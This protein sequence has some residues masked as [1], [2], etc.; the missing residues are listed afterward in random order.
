[1][2]ICLEDKMTIRDKCLPGL[3]NPPT[4]IDLLQGGRLC[5]RIPVLT[6]FVMEQ[7]NVPLSSHPRWLEILHDGLGH[8]IYAF[9]FLQG[10]QTTGFLPLAYLQ[11]RLLG[12]FLVSLPY[13][14][15]AGVCGQTAQIRT[16][17]VSAA[18]GLA[19]ELRVRFLELRHQT[20]LQHHLLAEPHAQKIHM[21]LTLPET[22]ETLWKDLDCKVR[23]QV[24][25]AEKAQLTITWGGLE[26]LSDFYAVFSRNMR[27]LG[28][29]VF[30]RQLF[31]SILTSFP[32]HAELCVV[33]KD[34]KP[35]AG[36]LLLH[37][38]GI[39]EVPSASSLREFNFTNANMLMYWNL[40]Q[41]AIQR[42]QALF[43][44]GRSSLNSPTF[45]FKKQ[46]GATPVSAAWQYYGRQGSLSQMRP[47]NPRYRLLIRTW[48][49]LP[50]WMANRIG[51]RVARLIP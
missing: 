23:N 24:R 45:R 29:P 6:Q 35:I 5:A 10:E 20:V 34:K 40:L 13:L 39:S 4:K 48:T 11:S 8:K 49:R 36:A 1:M 50:L 47:D 2:M 18:I 16:A 38:K 28:T 15:S 32:E 9:E 33:K 14:N 37:G 25:K 21:H 17:L 12:R 27:D 30:P 43:D 19:D 44:F 7:S 41:R 31:A 3:D 42:G 51:P 46:W 26:F 22:A